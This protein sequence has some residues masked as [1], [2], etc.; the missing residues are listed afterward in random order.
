MTNPSIPAS[1]I[2]VNHPLHAYLER[3]FPWLCI[4]GVVGDREPLLV[5]KDTSNCDLCVGFHH[6]ADLHAYLSTIGNGNITPCR[7]RPWG[8]YHL[9]P[10]LEGR[11]TSLYLR[12]RALGLCGSPLELRCLLGQ[13]SGLLPGIALHPG[14]LREAVLQCAERDLDEQERL[15]TNTREEPTHE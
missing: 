14:D 10:R 5:V 1:L 4:V 15:C 6:E 7:A 8:H 11:L 12:A 13:L 9:D 3:H 2:P